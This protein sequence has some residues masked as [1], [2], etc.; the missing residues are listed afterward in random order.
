MHPDSAHLT[1]GGTI[2]W[3][4]RA[5]SLRLGSIGETVTLALGSLPG[6]L[7]IRGD[8]TAGS[9]GW[10]DWCKSARTALLP[11]PTP[12]ARVA[13]ITL[14]G[15]CVGMTRSSRKPAAWNRR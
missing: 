11:G 15:E 9:S 2:N 3:D 8:E 5:V 12:Q 13:S 7:S 4:I 6:N 1:G 10:L 14:N